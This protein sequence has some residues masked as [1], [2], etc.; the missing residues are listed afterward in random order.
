VGDP[1]LLAAMLQARARGALNPRMAG[2]IATAQARQLLR[3]LDTCIRVMIILHFS[4][5]RTGSAESRALLQPC[6]LSMANLGDHFCR[7]AWPRF[8]SFASM[9]PQVQ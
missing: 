9:P 8:Q 5:H 7:G 2:P 3:Q 4:G 1:E 6:S